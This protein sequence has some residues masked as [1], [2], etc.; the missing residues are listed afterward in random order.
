ML[1]NDCGDVEVTGTE[2][3]VRAL[4][5]L[6][7]NHEVLSDAQKAIAQY[8]C[9]N[10][11]EGLKRTA[12]KI[13]VAVGVSASTLVRFAQGIG[14]QRLSDLQDALA[15]HVRTL[16]RSRESVERVK[17]VNEQF[18]LDRELDGYRVFLSVAAKEIEN[19]ERTRR[20]ISP[21]ALNEAVGRLFSARSVHVIGLRG[22]LSL[23]V[24]FMVRLRY[25]RPR[26]FRLD[27]AGDD[28]LDKLA[29]LH[30][31]DLLVAF[32]YSPYASTTIGAIKACRDLGVAV[33]AITDGERS[34]SLGYVKSALVTG[35]PL[36][37]SSSTA[38]T[39]ALVNA[40][41]FATAARSRS[42]AAA[43]IDR[44]RRLV[45]RLEKVEL[46]NMDDLLSILSNRRD[47]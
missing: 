15:I 45:E 38:G 22:S 19:I 29:R 7:L 11:W 33:L 13:G 25:V 37:F 40:L 18:G 14:F 5:D 42:A 26:V 34:P 46:S 28:L 8:L 47:D 27:N 2:G 21:E 1:R 23:A 24:H 4:D 44:A 30:A 39:T 32:S 10:P 20:S 16:L 36:W 17:F 43:H 41:I 6:L 31:E 12:A 35:N 3:G 9:E